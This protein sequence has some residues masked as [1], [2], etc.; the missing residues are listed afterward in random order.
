MT[1]CLASQPCRASIT[2]RCTARCWGCIRK[3]AEEPASGGPDVSAR[4]NYIYCLRKQRGHGADLPERS[5]TPDYS[6]GGMGK[7]RKRADAEADDAEPVSARHLPRRTN[8]ARRDCAAGAD[9]Q[10]PAFPQRDARAK[11]AA[12]HLCERVRNGSGAN[13]R[14]KL[15]GVGRQSARAERRVVHAGEPQSAEARVSE[16]VPGLRR[17]ADRPLSAGV[18]GD[19]ARL[20]PEN[21]AHAQ[22]SVTVLLTPGVSNSAYFEHT[23]LAQQMG[24]ELVEGRDLLV[25]DNVVYMRTTAGPRRVDVIYRRVDDDFLDP[26]CFR[27]IRFWACR[28]FQRVSRGERESG[29]CDRDGRGG[30]Q[31]RVCVCAGD[32]PVLSEGRSDSAECADV[33][34]DGRSQ[35]QHVLEHLEELVV[36]AVG[37]SGG[38]GMLIGPHSTRQQREEFRARILGGAAELYRTTDVC[39]FL[40]AVPD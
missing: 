35:R 27:P 22:R 25:H 39:A 18:A 36:K 19:F 9:L 40:R 32:H 30:R 10:L 21:C 15:R 12:G 11:C 16:D 24:I 3:I 31:G 37:E 17:L 6:R 23:F 7:N 8:P 34:A 29:E 1:R 5:D 26:L 33:P 4:R 20:T 2:N 28:D 38:Y 13:A 14:R